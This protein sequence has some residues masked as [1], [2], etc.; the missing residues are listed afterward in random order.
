MAFISNHYNEITYI[1]SSCISAIHAFT[2]R[3]GGIS[4]GIYTSLNLGENTGDTHD[5]VSENYR[6]ICSALSIPIENLVFSR[7]VHGTDI[8]EAHYSDT[9]T[10]FSV[11]PYEAD[12]LVTNEPDL[13][14]VIFT[15]DCIPLLLHDPVLGVISA[16][17]CGWRGTVGNIAGRAVQ[18]MQELYGCNPKNIHA[19][20]GPGISLCC[21]ETGD[22]VANAV[23]DILH[24]DADGFVFP[25]GEKFMVDLKGINR[26]LLE[27]SGVLSENI[28]ISDE[29]TMCSH[30]KYWSHRYTKGRRGSQASIIMLK[31]SAK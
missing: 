8:R 30:E 22:D 12:G 6:R 31:G 16:V 24:K 17:H 27:I 4:S 18:K 7:Q 14:L 9:H 26:R 13:P 21:F 29:C 2:T 23:Y 15:A 3:T 25:K 19:A 20:I 11:I 1:T 28:D 5:N 10:L